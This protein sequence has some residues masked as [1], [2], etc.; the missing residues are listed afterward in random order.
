[1]K[2]KKCKLSKIENMWLFSM[3]DLPVTDKQARNDYSHFRKMLLSR[4]FSM[5]QFSVYA[6]FC[7]SRETAETNKK[8]IE[9]CLPPEGQV[10]VFMITDKQFETMSVFYGT[11]RKEVEN[12]PEQLLLF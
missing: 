1:M 6:K 10:R 7:S 11:E 2:K 3:F 5:L 8:I 4:G 9:A 12:Q